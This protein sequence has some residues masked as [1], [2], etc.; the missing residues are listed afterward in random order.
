MAL[1][2]KA[3][4][5]L[6]DRAAAARH[7]PPLRGR[8]NRM[9]TLSFMTAN[10]VARQVG[11]QMPGGWAQGD[12]STQA[13]FKPKKRFAERFEVYIR[14]IQ[15]L[16]FTSIDLWTSILSPRWATDTHID[17]AADVLATYDMTV[18]SLAGEFGDDDETLETACDIAN[19]LGTSVLGGF[20]G[21]MAK[22][23][24]VMAD[25][26]RKYGVTFGLQNHAEATPD[27]LL[28]Q[29]GGE[30]GDQ[31]EDVMGVCADTGW[32]ASQA[33]PAPDA[34][35]TLAPRLLH[36]HLVDVLAAG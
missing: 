23:R 3:G 6:Y 22:N 5:P 33:Y 21:L 7:V 29:L 4:S 11:Y 35:R 26:L 20:C 12:A 27:A 18:S 28:A 2:R 36:V 9:T 8:V 25:L 16:G 30:A 13:H 32:W 1:T 24:P 17:A 10:Y 15:A 19:A 14:D 31:A 34:L